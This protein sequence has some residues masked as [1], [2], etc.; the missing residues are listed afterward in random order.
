MPEEQIAEIATPGWLKVTTWLL[1]ITTGII[2]IILFFWWREY[3]VKIDELASRNY[4]GKIDTGDFLKQGMS[5]DIGQL[6][7]DGN[8]TIN[9]DLHVT[10]SITSGS[11]ASAATDSTGYYSNYYTAGCNS[12][13]ICNSTLLQAAKEFVIQPSSP[14]V[15]GGT[16]RGNTTQAVDLLQLQ[17][18]SG[19]SMVNVTAN[20][21]LG[22]NNPSPVTTLDV[23]GTGHFTGHTAFGNVSAIDN[24]SILTPL[25]GTPIIRVNGT[26]EVLNTLTPGYNYYSGAS[27]EYFIN[28]GQSAT[29]HYFTGGY[30]A[31]EIVSGNPQDYLGLAGDAGLAIH[32][33]TGNIGLM[34][35]VLGYAY[36][37]SSGTL[38][39]AAGTFGY[40]KNNDSGTISNGN[41]A[42]GLLENPSTGSYDIAN[43]LSGQVYNGGVFGGGSGNIDNA[44]GVTAGVFNRSSGT[45]TNVSVIDVQAVTNTGGGTID[46]IRGIYIADQS[47]V[48]VSGVNYNLESMGTNSKNVF[49]GK[50]SVGGDSSV[51][52]T[53]SRLMI[54]HNPSLSW[55]T[56]DNAAIAQ[57][58]VSGANTALV[59]QGAAFSTGDLQQWQN[60]TGTVLGRITQDGAVAIGSSTS[61]THKLTVTDTT[62][63]D[64]AKFNGSGGTQCTVV[65][66]TGWSC[67][68]DESLKTNIVKIANGMDIVSQLQ[69]VT[70]NWKSDPTGTQQDGFIA[71]DIQ[72]ILPELVTTDSNGKLSLNKDGIMPFIVEAIKEQNGNIDKTNQQLADQG[73]KLTTLSDELV[74]LSKR[75]D[76]QN[77]D[78]QELKTQVQELN[79]RLQKL[80]PTT[81]APTKTTSAP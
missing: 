1:I 29:A 12:Q 57:I 52:G 49:H 33:G 44:N 43:G 3:T 73:I 32:E 60:Y 14:Y 34:G 37:N 59:V 81:T 41:G 8:A 24:P 17:N 19:Y 48:A 38:T 26:Q 62:T 30:H 68:S 11:N 76:Q 35:G 36:N 2:L 67:S 47:G 28:L 9:G 25:T 61:P 16:I 22:I 13:V 74:A 78:I 72:K 64:V 70:Y 42:G 20:G 69:G 51:F 4:V 31:G 54:N 10:G 80:E 53:N 5:A 40:L 58:N 45:I 18:A 79:N 65:T 46:N 7:V 56:T 71:Q 27:S 15:V 39:A 77:A 6:S 75:V 23:N 66:G 55:E 21:Q 63:T 50:V